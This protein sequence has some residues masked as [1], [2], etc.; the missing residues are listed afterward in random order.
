MTV[1]NLVH[2]W[3][4]V[5]AT[6]PVAQDGQAPRQAHPLDA[7]PRRPVPLILSRIEGGAAAQHSARAPAR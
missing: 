6:G 7:G 1:L 3:Q 4:Q 2:S 5:E